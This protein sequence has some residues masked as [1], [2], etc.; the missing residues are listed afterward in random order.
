MFACG[1][2]LLVGAAVVL[3]PRTIQATPPVSNEAQTRAELRAEFTRTLAA[4][5]ES[6][7][8]VFAVHQR[9]ATPYSEVVLWTNDDSNPGEIDPGEIAVVSHSQLLNAVT[10]YSLQKGSAA[11][12]AGG[13]FRLNRETV[14]QPAFCDRWRALPAVQ[15]RVI[16]SGISDMTLTAEPDG[17]ERLSHLRLGLRWTPHS[18]DGA[19]EASAL[20]DVGQ[21]RQGAGVIQP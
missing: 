12:R 10:V 16:G 3:D 11:A 2:V 9:G 7:V 18:T 20:I 21:R 8:E 14:I 13:G 17:Q 6:C 1:A 4:L 15:P 19:S 5:I